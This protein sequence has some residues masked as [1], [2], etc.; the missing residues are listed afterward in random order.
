MGQ[1]DPLLTYKTGPVNGREGRGSG[2]PEGVGVG[3]A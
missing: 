1:I 2:L 3:F